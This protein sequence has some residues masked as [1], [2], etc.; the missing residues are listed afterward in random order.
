MMSGALT[1]ATASGVLSNTVISESDDGFP[2]TAKMVVKGAG[3]APLFQTLTKNDK[4]PIGWN[5]EKFLVGRKGEVVG[6]FKSGVEP[7]ADELVTAI[8]KE[9]EKLVH[10]EVKARVLHSG[11]GAITESDV[12]LALTSPNDTIPQGSESISASRRAC[13]GTVLS[14]RTAMRGTP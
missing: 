7:T 9:L 8:K 12:I 14:E 6:R 4:E 13:S 5:F 11:I 10:D 1:A 3:Q 2:M